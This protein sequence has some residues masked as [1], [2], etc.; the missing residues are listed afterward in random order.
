MSKNK[1][2]SGGS[3]AL[4]RKTYAKVDHNIAKYYKCLNNPFKATSI[5]NPPQLPDMWAGKSVPICVRF[6]DII[7]TD[8]NGNAAV[9]FFPQVR[10]FVRSHNTITNN[11]PAYNQPIDHP[12]FE[13]FL[14]S[15][16]F[17]RPILLATRSSYIGNADLLAGLRSSIISTDTPEVE[18]AAYGQEQG[19]P[20]KTEPVSRNSMVSKALL[21]DRPDFKP[22]DSVGNAAHFDTMGNITLGWTGLPSSSACVYVES[23]F[24]VEVIPETNSTLSFAEKKAPVSSQPIH[25]R[26]SHHEVHQ[27]GM[28]V[29]VASPAQNPQ[30]LAYTPGR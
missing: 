4:A 23:V 8:V 3:K 21:F 12:Q 6:N 13:S 5:S 19:T 1:A 18:I 24:Y 29:V 11:I 20:A 27:P 17:I 28:D 10:E 25:N 14:D 9:Q 22:V 7:T 26:P 15:T 30:Q 2:K 16:K